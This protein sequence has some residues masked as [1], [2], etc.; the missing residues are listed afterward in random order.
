MH[1]PHNLDLGS[2]NQTS[3]SFLTRAEVPSQIAHHL[4]NNSK[5]V[6]DPNAVPERDQY[7]EQRA[8]H[9]LQQYTRSE[10]RNFSLTNIKNLAAGS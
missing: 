6:I 3:S 1:H 10:C 5:R 4:V 2:L 9:I 8:R 7:V